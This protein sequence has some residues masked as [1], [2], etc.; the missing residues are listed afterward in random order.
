MTTPSLGEGF[1][2]SAQILREKNYFA[3]E[4]PEYAQFSQRNMISRAYYGI[5]HLS[6]DFAHRFAEV[7][8]IKKFDDAEDKVHGNLKAFYSNTFLNLKKDIPERESFDIIATNLRELRAARNNCDYQT[9]LKYDLNK[10]VET[11]FRLSEKTKLE[12]EKLHVWL[13]I[14]QGEK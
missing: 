7:L 12:I 13:D 9:E 14:L 3:N 1:L 2:K 5:F 8:N 10:K 11:I 6:K 4:S